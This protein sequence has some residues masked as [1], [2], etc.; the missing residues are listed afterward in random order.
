MDRYQR[1]EKPRPEEPIKENEIRITA[2]GLIRNYI[3]YATTL[4]QEKWEQEIVLKAM[5]QAISK[6]VAI[7]EIIKLNNHY[8]SYEPIEE[9]LEP[10]EMTRQVSLISITLSTNE[11]NKNS[12][13]YQAPSRSEQPRG[14]HQQQPLQPR[15]AGRMVDFIAIIEAVDEPD[16]G[17]IVV[18]DT[19][20]AGVDFKLGAKVM[21][22]DAEGWAEEEVVGIRH[23]LRWFLFAFKAKQ[24]YLSFNHK[25]VSVLLA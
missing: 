23:N 18:W 8:Y 2:Q 9:G 7:A 6:S 1:V 4:L 5:G 19:E 20:G 10:L 21:V 3:S 24:F 16:A 22:E 17:D 14:E 12:P 25:E 15:K 11:L 13:G